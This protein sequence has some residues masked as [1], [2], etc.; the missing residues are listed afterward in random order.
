MVLSTAMRTRSLSIVDSAAH[1]ALPAQGPT[2]AHNNNADPRSQRPSHNSLKCSSGKRFRSKSKRA[3][4]LLDL[5]SALFAI[6]EWATVQTRTDHLLARSNKYLDYLLS[7]ISSLVFTFLVPC[8]CMRIK[9]QNLCAWKHWLVQKKNGTEWDQ[10]LGLHSAAFWHST[11]PTP[12]AFALLALMASWLRS[13]NHLWG[14]C[15]FVRNI[16]W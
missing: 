10:R 5:M 9:S 11:R 1:K 4:I 2:G 8:C 6:P 16:D 3:S 12:L 14:E 13:L 15:G 7:Y